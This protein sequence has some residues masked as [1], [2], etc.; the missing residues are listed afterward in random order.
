VGV[1]G[2]AREPAG[3]PSAPRRGYELVR[4]TNPPIVALL[5]FTALASAYVAG[6]AGHRVQVAI[7]VTA[8]ALSSMGARALTN[9][10][11]RDIDARMERTRSRPLPAGTLEPRTALV[12]GLSLAV[13]GTL[14]A[15]MLGP[16][17]ALLVVAGLLDNI[18]V[19]N[20]V[21]KRRTVWNIVLAAPSGGIPALVGYVGITGRIELVGL[22]LMALVVLWTPI[23]IWSLAIR[24][25]E[26][27]AKAG[28]P[29]LPVTVGVAP[30]IRSIAAA[31]VLLAVFT[32][33][34]PL[35]PGA[36]FG[37]LTLVVAAAFG[38]AMLAFSLLL[39]VRPTLVSAW[40]LFK[41]TSPYLAVLFS[42]MA[43]DVAVVRPP[44]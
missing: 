28:V 2:A 13:A 37:R 35:V 27:Y 44:W 25:R 42:V 30:A 14:V 12:F 23:H 29:M 16:L 40:R 33:C 18:V 20:L 15:L 39:M 38:A 10:V 7:I 19:Y 17:P 26:D 36:P 43:L 9:Y 4:L 8:I 3:A 6:G 31:T 11:D 21:S 24:Y 22:L 32:V 41:F 5:V 1:S 34:L